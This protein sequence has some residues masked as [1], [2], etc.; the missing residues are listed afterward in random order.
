MLVEF[1]TEVSTS[2]G[3]KTVKEVAELGTVVLS[4]IG[5]V[6]SFTLCW[7]FYQSKEN[8]A[9]RIS[10]DF[11]TDG[12]YHFVTLVMGLGLVFN[13]PVVIN[14]DIIFRP[15]VICLNLIAMWRLFKHLKRA[16]DQ[17]LNL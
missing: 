7:Y 1:L 16:I 9:R 2:D 13:M 15:F 14:W 4:A 6:L 11:F 17:E 3:F 12:L 8:L 10:D 5:V